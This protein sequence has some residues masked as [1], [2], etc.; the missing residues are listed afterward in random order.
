MLAARNR[1]IHTIALVTALHLS[2]A[3]AAMSQLQHP[4][5]YAFHGGGQDLFGFS[6]DGAG[7]V[8]RDG[9]ADVVVGAWGDDT[10]GALSGSAWVYSGRDG[11]VL[12]ALHGRVAGELFGYSVAAAG[13]ID[14][15]GHADVI[16]SAVNDSRN[17]LRAGAAFVISGRTGGVLH[18]WTGDAA[19]DLFGNRV[20]SAGDVD[21]DGVPDLIV[22]A[23]DGLN[24]QN[25]RSGYARV[26]S[27]KTGFVLRTL[28]GTQDAQLFGYLG[29]G[30]GDIN[31]DGH[32]DFAIG[33]PHDDTGGI[34]AGCIQVVSGKDGTTIFRHYGRTNDH[35]GRT[36]DGL[37]DVDGD[38][39]P[40]MV[41]G[42]EASNHKDID[43]RVLV[44]SG[45]GRVLHTLQGTTRADEFGMSV[46][47]IGD[48]NGDGRSDFAVGAPSGFDARNRPMGYVRIFSGK[49]ASVI[50]TL[51]GTSSGGYFGYSVAGAGDVNAD[52]SPDF[53]VGGH[54][55]ATHGPYAGA[56]LVFSGRALELTTDVHEISLA[57]G[58]AQ[59]FVMDAGVPHAGKPFLLLG[60][61]SGRRPGIGL[62]QLTLPVNLDAYCYFLLENPNSWIAGSAGLLDASGRASATLVLPPNSAQS[63]IGLRLDHA[64]TAFQLSPL[65]F[66]VASNATSLVLIR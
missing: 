13:D 20:A 10:N 38:G 3:S 30:I 7:D 50:D 52:G 61:S 26:F 59:R 65:S 35:L 51:F 63:L 43:G 56:A 1:H 9:Y 34:D 4:H 41:V 37:G 8:D 36:I 48:V 27:G 19:L 28:Y 47:S 15:D 57:A 17:G 42:G 24:P 21:A 44:I 6:V 14:R 18:T 49:D 16:V 32:G 11:T 60:S 22:G 45:S 12:H 39:L 40:D 2:G 53:V 55:E 29:T 5:V 46:G 66:E 54:H 25:L 23:A 33:A 64:F 31:R 62:G 58:G